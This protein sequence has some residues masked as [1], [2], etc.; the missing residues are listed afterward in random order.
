M[1]TSKILNKIISSP[2]LFLASFFSLLVGSTISFIYQDITSVSYLGS[3]GF[4]LFILAVIIGIITIIYSIILKKW[5]QLIIY[6]SVY[7]ILFVLFIMAN[8]MMAFMMNTGPK[9][10][11]GNKEFYADAFKYHSSLTIANDLEI[12]CKQDTIIGIGPGGGDYKAVCIFSIDKNQTNFI[13]NKLNNDT[14]YQRVPLSETILDGT[15]VDDHPDLNCSQAITYNE[16]GYK[17]EHFNSLY[18]YI[19]FSKD[20]NHMLFCVDYY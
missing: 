9:I 1:N 19:I 8:F 16:Y 6:I 7:F 18:S 12:L 3:V 11:K 4:G 5:R 2:I 17:S 14:I 15:W 20:K 13:E 10:I